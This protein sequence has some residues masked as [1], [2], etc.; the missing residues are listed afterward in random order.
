[1]I[2]RACDEARQRRLAAPRLADEPHALALADREAHVVDGVQAAAA[3]KLKM[4]LERNAFD[5]RRH[6]GLQHT[7]RW[8]G[9]GASSAR[10]LL[11]RSMLRVQRSR[12]RQA[13]RSS[14]RR[15]GKPPGMAAR[16]S[17]AMPAAGVAA[18][19]C[20]V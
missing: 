1:G 17:S 11:Q 13:G 4:L 5:E 3:A 8:P 16:F 15:S 10:A 12:K 19:S 9:S 18:M 14:R 20:A 6:S 7:T 2:E